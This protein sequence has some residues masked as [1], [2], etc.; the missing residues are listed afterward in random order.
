[1]CFCYHSLSYKLAPFLN[2]LIPLRKGG[3]RGLCFFLGLFYNPQ[4]P[5]IKGDFYTHY[6]L[7][8]INKMKIPILLNYAEFPAIIYNYELLLSISKQNP[9][10]NLDNVLSQKVFSVDNSFLRHYHF[11][12]ISFHN[13][14]QYKKILLLFLLILCVSSL[15]APLIKIAAD[16][17]IPQSA[18]VT[19]LL[20]YKHGSYDFGRVMRRIVMG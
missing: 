2:E 4:A 12:M 7:I 14:K 8:R 19:D 1:M 11:T 13:L 9:Y 5:F 6:L 16:M 10:L 3:I 15:L 18:L 17:L 20:N